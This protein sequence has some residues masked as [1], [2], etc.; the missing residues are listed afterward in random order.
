[1]CE[2]EEHDQESALDRHIKVHESKG[3]TLPYMD[4]FFCNFG[5]LKGCG[6]DESQR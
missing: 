3:S 5:L 1:M 6:F 2:F 4:A